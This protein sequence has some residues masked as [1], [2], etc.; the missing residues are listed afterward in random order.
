M[1]KKLVGRLIIFVF[2]LAMFTGVMTNGAQAAVLNS[3]VLTNMN[4]YDTTILT[5]SL[6]ET[7]EL[8]AV[9]QEFLANVGTGNT[10]DVYNF[11]YIPPGGNVAVNVYVSSSDFTYAIGETSGNIEEAIKMCVDY[12]EQFP[13][14]K[15]VTLY[16]TG[17]N[18]SLLFQGA[19]VM[20]P[21]SSL[22]IGRYAQGYNSDIVT[23]WA[24]NVT[25][26]TTN[27]IGPIKYAF[28]KDIDKSSVNNIKVFLNDSATEPASAASIK[29][30]LFGKF[31]DENLANTKSNELSADIIAS[32]DEL[33][34]YLSL[35]NEG[36]AVTKIRIEGKATDQTVTS[37]TI[38][39]K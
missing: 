37:F 31:V 38:N 7:G 5:F 14:S 13:Q 10:A 34:G 11:N 3:F 17:E 18:Y 32:Y 26:Q 9:A 12:S 22:A 24:T 33:K 4:E 30:L 23:E 20:N 1:L 8:Y 16:P 35:Y 21:G 6:G 2:S 15:L 28:E 19:T 27:P 25:A 36:N 29:E 39:L